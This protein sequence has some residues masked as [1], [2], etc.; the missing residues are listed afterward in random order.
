MTRA[1]LI[2]PHGREA[3][4]A[5]WAARHEECYVVIPLKRRATPQHTRRVASRTGF[6]AQVRNTSLRALPMTTGIGRGS[7]LVYEPVRLKRGS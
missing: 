7:R 4:S 1:H 6:G 5:G 3:D 2:N